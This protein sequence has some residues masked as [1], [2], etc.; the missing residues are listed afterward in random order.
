MAAAICSMRSVFSQVVAELLLELQMRELLERDRRAALAVGLVEELRVGEAGVGDERVAVAA[1][2]SG[3]P[4][5]SST[6]RKELVSFPAASRIGSC[7]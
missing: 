6:A 3:S 7:F 1:L 4:S 2:P 5:L